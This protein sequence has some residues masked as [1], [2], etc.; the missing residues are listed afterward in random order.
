MVGCVA[1]VAF[2]CDAGRPRGALAPRVRL[3]LVIISLIECVLSVETECGP[4]GA[5]I[6]S[7]YR[8]QAMMHNRLVLNINNIVIRPYYGVCRPPEGLRNSLTAQ[9]A[10]RG[11]EAREAYLFIRVFFLV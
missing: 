9:R 6:R 4:I 1:C 5:G 10:L 11:S 8:Y 2:R 7:H 3:L